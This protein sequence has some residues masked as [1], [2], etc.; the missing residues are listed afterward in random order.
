SFKD[1][2]PPKFLKTLHQYYPQTFLTAEKD[3]RVIGYAVA[4]T[5]TRNLGHVLSIAVH[6]N[7]RRKGAGE[8]LTF[9]MLEVLKRLGVTD[10]RLEVRKSNTPAQRLYEKLNFRYS[11][12]IRGYYGDED[13][14]VYFKTL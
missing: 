11:H 13:A 6:P 9:K 1:P 14:L 10:V 5:H 7:E 8:A 3:G 12:T 4:I 2:Y